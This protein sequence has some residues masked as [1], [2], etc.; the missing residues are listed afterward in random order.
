M[1]RFRSLLAFL[2][3]ALALPVS[4]QTECPDDDSSPCS[5]AALVADQDAV[6]PGTAFDVALRIEIEPK[7]HVYWKNPG[8][9][10]LQVRVEWDNAEAITVGPLQNPYPTRIDIAG[11]TSYAFE[12]EANLLAR[13]AVPEDFAGDELVLSGQAM[14]LICADICLTAEQPVSLTL[15]IGTPSTTGQLDVARSLLPVQA[16]GWRASASPA[17]SSVV[18]HLTPPQGWDGSLEGAQF[19]PAEEGVLDHA[20]PQTF[21][22]RPRI[23]SVELAPSP[24]SGGSIDRIQGV[25]VA[26]EGEALVGDA[27]AIEIDAI[28]DASS[29]P[30][31]SQAG[32]SLAWALLFALGGGMILNLMPC[33]F[34]ILSIKVL[35]FAEGKDGATLRRNGLA[36]GAGVLV[37]FWALAGLLLALRAAGAGLGWGFQ[38]QSPPIVAALAALMVLIGLN[39]LGVFEIGNGLAA[40]GAK[41]DRKSGLGGAFLSGVL[42]TIVATPCTAPFMGAALGYAIAAPVASSLLVFTALGI[43]MAL[44]YV[45]L[46]FFP[47][48]TERLPRPGPWM[49]TLRQALAFPL[50]ATAVWLLWVFGLQ[51]GMNG[52]ALLLMALV[53]L[54]LATWLIGH[55]PAHSTSSKTRAITRGLAVLSVA[56]ALALAIPAAQGSA[57]SAIVYQGQPRILQ[58]GGPWAIGTPDS[59]FPSEL[60][61]LAEGESGWLPFTS[62]SV[63]QMVAD[64][65]PVFIDFTAAWCLTCQVNKKTTLHT[66]AVQE[67]F[68]RAG[69]T[70]VRAD[71]TNRNPDITATLDRFGRSGVPFYVLYPGGDAEPILLPET[72]T[73]GIVIDALES[74][75]ATSP[76]ASL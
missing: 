13:V 46:S 52:V 49:V 47:K 7:W 70:R 53:L 11:L 72:L 56:A 71:W 58:G 36:F 32:L 76:T 42:A 30:V 35:G 62:A 26:A 51:V 29:T 16:E 57:G 69:V 65:Q 63:D 34:P 4:A 67:A 64:G 8:D 2:A 48:W 9:A 54:A 20:A 1:S 14:W 73:P 18:L 12:N 37:S 75:A 33:V 40:A 59:E 66:E 22:Y 28:V 21:E 3:L 55:W 74:L 61:A 17:D 41:A 45:L 44:P 15:P 27:R 31:S 38:L 10:G 23:W 6:E 39:L 50:F 19:F 25:L 43:G 24:V 5:N 68:E 60:A